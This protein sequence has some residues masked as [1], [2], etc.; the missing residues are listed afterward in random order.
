MNKPKVAIIVVLVL[1][2]IVFPLLY[3]FVFDTNQKKPITEPETFTMHQLQIEPFNS[4][5]YNYL[6]NDEYSAF[7]IQVYDYLLSQNDKQPIISISSVDYNK[8]TQQITV[9]AISRKTNQD[10]K[11]VIDYTETLVLININNSGQKR[12]L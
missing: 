6:T 4:E 7:K 2:F 12:L 11:I 10:L 9:N 3:F 5:L 1:A 8:D